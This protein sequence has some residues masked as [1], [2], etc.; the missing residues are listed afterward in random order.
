MIS[1]ETEKIKRTQEGN[2]TIVVLSDIVQ[3]PWN[4][5]SFDIDISSMNAECLKILKNGE[6]REIPML[7]GVAKVEDAMSDTKFL[8]V[9]DGSTFL[10]KLSN[11]RVSDKC[12][13]RVFLKNGKLCSSWNTHTGASF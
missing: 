2:K 1:I 12:K 4:I 9:G 8:C 11:V 13:G 5:F 10:F 3:T 6:V 7:D